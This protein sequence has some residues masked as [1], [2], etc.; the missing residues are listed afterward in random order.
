MDSDE[1]QL[2]RLFEAYREATPDPEVSAAFMPEL[3][4]K[5]DSKRGYVVM[6]KRWTRALATAAVA[7][8]IAMTV[9]MA[10]PG[11]SEAA[12]YATTYVESLDQNEDFEVSAYA[13][14]VSFDPAENGGIR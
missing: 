3:W 12:D 1:Q 2:D 7:A 10:A 14:F 8:C 5:I 4:N 6:V 13:E 11:E 9:Y